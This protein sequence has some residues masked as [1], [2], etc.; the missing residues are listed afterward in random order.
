MG[1]L[2]GWFGIMLKSRFLFI[3]LLFLPL[4]A[5]SQANNR[6]PLLSLEWADSL[7]RPRVRTAVIGAAVVYPLAMTGLWQSWYAD[8]PL[9]KFHFFNDNR[10][11]NQMDK[12][13]HWFSG[14]Q[15]AR[16]GWHLSRWAGWNNK[17]SAWIGFGLGQLVQTSFE[18]MDG[19]SEQWGF[20][21]GDIALIRLAPVCLQP[22][23]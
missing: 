10:E 23:N 2:K 15:E 16:L 3:F 8:Y 22:S 11:W 13:G 12:M 9:G 4:F 20:S 21:P 6:L 18:V 1:H 19:F 14:Y 17:K 5:F 7:H